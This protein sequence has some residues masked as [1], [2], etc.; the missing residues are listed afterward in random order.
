MFFKDK[1]STELKIRETLNFRD[2]IVNIVNTQTTFEKIAD[3]LIV[4]S[5][6]LLDN[7]EKGNNGTFGNSDPVKE[8]VVVASPLRSTML[9][10]QLSRSFFFIAFVI[11]F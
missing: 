9:Q 5:K 11:T 2:D 6:H 10:I 3:S 4:V 8:E 7:S 1:D